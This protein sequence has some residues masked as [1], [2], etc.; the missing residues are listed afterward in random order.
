MKLED[1]NTDSKSQLSNTISN[2][3][4][5]ASTN[6]WSSRPSKVIVCW[7]L[8]I[9][10]Y[11]LNRTTFDWGTLQD[12]VLCAAV[13]FYRRIALWFLA[14]NMDWFGNRWDCANI[15]LESNQCEKI[16]Y[17]TI[18]YLWALQCCGLFL[19][20]FLWGKE[21]NENS[22]FTRVV[23]SRLLGKRFRFTE[24]CQ[25][26]CFKDNFQ[27]V[28]FLNDSFFSFVS[29]VRRKLSI[30]GCDYNWRHGCAVN[31]ILRHMC[32]WCALRHNS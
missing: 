5:F 32:C 24:V 17:S 7:R 8:K 15:P 26:F 20:D 23:W 10:C 14:I 1:S 19:C 31:L 4:P 25:D 27:S 28:S 18:L 2:C 30:L 11:G 29:P 16:W 9:S 12:S 6:W 3:Q 21:T 13:S 22:V